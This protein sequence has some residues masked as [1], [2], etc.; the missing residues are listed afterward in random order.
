VRV[1]DVVGIQRTD[2]PERWNVGVVRWMK[3][4]ETSSLQM[5]VE[6]LA[7]SVQPVSI[8]P[9]GGDNAAPV[10]FAGLLLPAMQVPPQ[11]A[12]LLAPRGI[13]QLGRDVW[14]A[15]E[16]IPARLVRPLQRLQQTGSVEQFV[17]ADVM[18]E[19]AGS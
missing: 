7:P 14:L 1:G 8:R 5:G 10:Y 13:C 16:N 17:C 11:P 2:D 12:T 9:G 4:P 19:P 6:L 3:S 18:Q 15:Q